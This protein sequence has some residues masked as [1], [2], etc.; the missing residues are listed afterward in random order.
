MSSSSSSA[1]IGSSSSGDAATFKRGLRLRRFSQTRFVTGNIDAFR[2]R[3]VAYGAFEMPN[4]VFLYGKK[5]HNPDVGE[6]AS[7]FTSVCSPADLEDYPIGDS[8]EIPA[9]FRKDSVDLVL[10]SK[11][12]ADEA[13]RVIQADVASLIRALDF[14]DDLGVVEDAVLGDPP[15]SEP[16]V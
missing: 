10:R 12:M 13:W 8:T 3:V 9:F 4:E 7:L 1:D 6:S 5:I 11:A 16:P 2:F 14:G 15:P